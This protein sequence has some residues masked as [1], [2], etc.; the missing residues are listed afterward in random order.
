MDTLK[1]MPA[2]LLVVQDDLFFAARVRQHA[3][4]LAIDVELVSPSQV[5]QLAGRPDTVVMLQVTLNPERQLG[6]I[7][8]LKKLEP[9]PVVIAV[10]GHLETELRKR[11]KSLGA[12]L[13]SN[14]G[15]ERVLERV[16][17]PQ[18]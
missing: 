15:L 11:A 7:E 14:S 5:E 1:H 12:I 16:G 10:S 9:A 13:A 18:S 3:S 8:R 4:R 6:L 17:K 2:R